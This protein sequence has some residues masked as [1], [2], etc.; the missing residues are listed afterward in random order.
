MPPE[1]EQS[2]RSGTT[3]PFRDLSQRP[4]QEG[5]V[6]WG[7]EAPLSEL[8]RRELEKGTDGDKQQELMQHP[9]QLE[10]PANYGL[11]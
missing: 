6:K 10:D 7:E 9:D 2:H 5:R 1:S 4:G 11:S 3:L 8:G